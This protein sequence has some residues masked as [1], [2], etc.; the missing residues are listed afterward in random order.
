MCINSFWSF[1]SLSGNKLTAEKLNKPADVRQTKEVSKINSIPQVAPPT[2]PVFAV[3]TFTTAAAAKPKEMWQPPQQPSKILKDPKETCKK[4]QNSISF[5][6][7]E[8]EIL[9]QT[10]KTT[11]SSSKGSVFAPLPTG[12]VRGLVLKKLSQ[13]IA[14]LKE[15]QT[16][17]VD[18][19]ESQKEMETD[20]GIDPQKEESRPIPKLKPRPTIISAKRPEKEQPCVGENHG[21]D[22]SSKQDTQASLET[23][24]P[25]PRSTLIKAKLQERTENEE[26]SPLTNE[27]V[28]QA[29]TDS[30]PS[31][32]SMK[33][34]PTIITAK[35]KPSCQ[36]ENV[37]ESGHNVGSPTD[38][39]AKP[40]VVPLK[41]KSKPTI[42]VAKPPKLT[43]QVK[44][45]EDKSTSGTKELETENT[46]KDV[47]SKNNAEKQDTQPLEVSKRKP[48]PTIIRAVKAPE[49]PAEQ[50][51]G[52]RK[53]ERKTTETSSKS[54][55][56]ASSPQ[57]Q[58]T[59]PKP[60]IIYAAK[61]PTE[62]R[63]APPRP[64]R[65][66]SVKTKPNNGRQQVQPKVETVRDPP[67]KKK[68]V[69]P[70]STFYVDFDEPAEV[71]ETK[72]SSAP[73][74]K[75]K[76]QNKVPQN[77]APP[78]PR[79]GSVKGASAKAPEKADEH[80]VSSGDQSD[81]A[82]TENQS[83]SNDKNLE[84]KHAP[85]LTE[86]AVENAV[87]R[88]PK[89]RPP[90]PYSIAIGE[91]ASKPNAPAAPEEKKTKPRPPRPRSLHAE[92]KTTEP[93]TEVEV[94]L[95]KQQEEG[96]AKVKTKPET[97]E[98]PDTVAHVEA[99]KKEEISHPS[100]ETPLDST[101]IEKP[102]PSRPAPATAGKT[103][104]RP[105]RPAPSISR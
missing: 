65:T 100:D 78:P 60:T 8:K 73:K 2:V 40:E 70:F 18:T 53:E 56:L 80:K 89:P 104:P 72:A 68:P 42:I 96:T 41:P 76:T 29:K 48:K 22:L 31:P 21:N 1:P 11:T 10:K 38:E 88:K 66:P 58:R 71:V 47:S 69:L 32:P 57:P 75:D 99:V 62:K 27:T 82:K 36:S 90:R 25:K 26:T 92:A 79:P 15:N 102:K 17:P 81:T 34:R 91:S 105:A 23:V 14:T 98:T 4:D 5:S 55:E 46:E 74:T 63:A 16:K 77:R 67:R 94:R 85:A 44:P 83:T 95:E 20:M 52:E 28:S 43:K 7:P 64:T 12:Q 97:K 49:K 93:K 51:S 37:K 103:K 19:T 86:P 87:M 6:L 9:E 13:D 39:K 33:S 61:P 101:T 30:I 84:L 3:K 24:T 54:N 35:T 45:D 50:N 59:K